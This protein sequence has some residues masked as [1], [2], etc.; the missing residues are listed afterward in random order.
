[1][2]ENRHNAAK[3]CATLTESQYQPSCMQRSSW[4]CNRSCKLNSTTTFITDTNYWIHCTDSIPH[5]VFCRSLASVPANVLSN[6]RW[7]TPH[8]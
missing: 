7:T 5:S 4:D 8:I 3:C 6:R 1:M 2:P